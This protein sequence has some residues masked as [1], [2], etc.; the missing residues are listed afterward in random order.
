M[1]AL[2]EVARPDRIDLAIEDGQA[3]LVAIT[4]RVVRSGG[5]PLDWL[6]ASGPRTSVWP[7]MASIAVLDGLA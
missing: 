6:S 4:E 2:I 5:Y 1:V 3:H 7:V